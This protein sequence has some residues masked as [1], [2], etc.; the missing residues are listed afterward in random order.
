MVLNPKLQLQKKPM[1]SQQSEAK[2]VKFND[3]SNNSAMSYRT[4]N[5]DLLEAVLTGLF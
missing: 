3:A 5:T 2:V 1:T 4:P